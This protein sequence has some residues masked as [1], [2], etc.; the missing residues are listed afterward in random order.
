M[1]DQF[2]PI[3]QPLAS[4][5]SGS[6]KFIIIF[7]KRLLYSDRHYN[8]FKWFHL[9]LHKFWW[10][11]GP[12]QPLIS[13]LISPKCPVVYVMTIPWGLVGPLLSAVLLFLDW[14]VLIIFPWNNLWSSSKLTVSGCLWHGSWDLLSPSEGTYFEDRVSH[15]P[16]MF[17]SKSYHETLKSVTPPFSILWEI[18]GLSYLSFPHRRVWTN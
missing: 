10:A 16:Q 15:R 1:L 7:K 18:H 9:C 6:N 14:G 13:Y 2:P 12:K 17:P 4:R 3:L 11:I 5:F 8:G